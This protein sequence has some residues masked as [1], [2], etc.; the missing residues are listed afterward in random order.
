MNASDFARQLQQQGRTYELHS[1]V[2]GPCVQLRFTGPFEQKII[3][4]DAE[5]VTLAYYFKSMWM[6]CVGSGILRPFIVVGHTTERGRQ[7]QIGLNVAT[8]DDATIC[9]TMIMI[10]QYKRLLA[11]RLEFG[12]PYCTSEDS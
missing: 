7:L 10:R 6:E 5:I 3:I 2:P 9:K 8:I 12:E 4:W 1:S 11:G